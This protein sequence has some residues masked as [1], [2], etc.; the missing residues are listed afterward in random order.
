MPVDLNEDRML[1]SMRVLDAADRL[2]AGEARNAQ[3]QRQNRALELDA[4]RVG[5]AEQQA[6][7]EA[8]RNSLAKQR[9]ELDLRNE[10]A[11]LREEQRNINAE[12]VKL[13]EKNRAA[14]A[15]S[16]A[17]V[18]VPNI[19]LDTPEG[20]K[21]L[22]NWL[23]YVESNGVD[24]ES[25]RMIFGAKMREKDVKTEYRVRTQVEA[26]GN[27][28]MEV[29]DAFRKNL[30]YDPEK[31]G[32]LASKSVRAQ[33]TYA[34][35]QKL[36]EENGVAFIPTPEDMASMK[37]RIGASEKLDDGMSGNT[38]DASAHF[39][40][41]DAVN[42]VVSKYVTPELKKKVALDAAKTERDTREQEARISKTISESRQAEAN[43]A[44]ASFEAGVY[45]NLP[46]TN[47]APTRTPSPAANLFTN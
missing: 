44:K 3:E 30:Q 28:G 14:E 41:I 38:F 39:W 24:D 13:W 22:S 31:S 11:V 1:A 20:T 2:R 7:M 29:Y 18:A 10:Q 4:Q 6:A 16:Y 25:K 26:L 40:D 47:A 42:A 27:D 17:A 23:S 43:A 15:A 45:K 34:Y 35:W 36:A 21:E 19:N 8:E 37:K 32:R 33:Q 9:F 46:N 5:I 12:N